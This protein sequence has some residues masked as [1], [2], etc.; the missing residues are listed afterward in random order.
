MQIKNIKNKNLSFEDCFE[1]L[2]FNNF[3][4][5]TITNKNK[6]IGIK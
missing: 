6:I 1:I 2:K 4:L 3:F 5:K